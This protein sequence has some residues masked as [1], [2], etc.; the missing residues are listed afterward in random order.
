MLATLFPTRLHV[1]SGI[2]SSPFSPRWCKLERSFHV[3]EKRIFPPLHDILRYGICHNV[4]AEVSREGRLM[5]REVGMSPLGLDSRK[6]LNGAGSQRVIEAAERR[7]GTSSSSTC[8]SPGRAPGYRRRVPT[9]RAIR[10]RTRMP[11][12]RCSATQFCRRKIESPFSKRPKPALARAY[13]R[14]L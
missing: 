1:L 3:A 13:K 5:R 12:L 14:F 6:Y 10:G 7:P 11:T 2:D 4:A 9:R 8:C